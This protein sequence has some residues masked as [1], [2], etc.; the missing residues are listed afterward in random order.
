[1]ENQGKRESSQEFSMQMIGVSFL[2]LCILGLTF[3]IKY[4]L[5]YF[6]EG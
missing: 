6:F 4:G 5:S 1:M 3:L 2:I